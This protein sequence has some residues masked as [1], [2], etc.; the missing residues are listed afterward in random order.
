[1]MSTGLCFSLRARR[2]GLYR[3]T[4]QKGPGGNCY[5]LGDMFILHLRSRY[6]LD[7]L[8]YTAMSTLVIEC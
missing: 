2:P 7:R 1:M 4:R 5:A 3:R 8:D 6:L